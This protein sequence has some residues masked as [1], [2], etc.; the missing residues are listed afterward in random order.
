M[1]IERSGI[2]FTPDR[3]TPASSP[4]QQTGTL[5]GSRA[6]VDPISFS[7]GTRTVPQQTTGAPARAAD[8]F[9]ILKDLEFTEDGLTKEY[10]D[11]ANELIQMQ[12]ASARDG[13]DVRSPDPSNPDQ[14]M[15]SQYYTKLKSHAQNL[16]NA[17]QQTRGYADNYAQQVAMG[18]IRPDER[19]GT[20]MTTLRNLGQMTAQ[21][22]LHPIVAEHNKQYA[23]IYTREGVKQADE[24]KQGIIN[25]LEQGKVLASRQGNIR[26]VQRLDESIAALE[27]HY[28]DPTKDLDRA[29]RERA[30]QRAAASKKGGGTQD[31]NV[32]TDLIWKTLHHKDI[33]WI[34]RSG[35][36][37]EKTGDGVRVYKGKV[38]IEI[39]F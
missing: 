28:Y 19:A 18:R 6:V 39:N 3:F 35:Y 13:W 12:E 15:A 17:L 14:Y 26:E 38:P 37:V 29:Q 25:E 8:D 21:A 32:V 4:F 11:S 22:G 31:Y 2:R 27:N 23:N 34:R 1:A 33:D 10:Y 30:S 24:Y 20:R 36:Q 5:A 9:T 16:G 7:S